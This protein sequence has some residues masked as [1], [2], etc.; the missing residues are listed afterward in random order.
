MK[1]FFLGTNGWFDTHTGNSTCILMKTRGAYIILDAGGGLYKACDIIKD[2]KPAYML[3]THLHMDHIQGLQVLPLFNWA[4]GLKIITGSGGKK[5]LESIMR[6]PFMPAPVDL[7]MKTEIT[8]L[9]E[10]K[11]L[12]FKLTAREMAHIVPTLGYR[13]EAE[14][15]TIVYTGDTGISPEAVE[16]AA[17]ADL[18]ITECSHLPGQ[19]PNNNHLNPEQA[20]QLAKDAKA[21]TL[22]LIHFKADTYNTM[23]LR[24]KAL[25]AAGRV[26][27]YTMAPYDGDCLKF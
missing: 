9:P 2:D 25:A 8:E 14:D 6:H 3:L 15:K 12:P 10:V 22:A 24:D 13:I 17:N 11:N 1:V 5:E 21:K 7:K 16:L 26:F 4:G 23:E 27:P 19:T 20:A 18:L